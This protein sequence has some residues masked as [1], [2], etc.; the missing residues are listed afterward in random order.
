M[1]LTSGTKLGPYEIQSP[2]GAGG[3]GEVYRAR[4]TRLDR[5]VA[6]KVLPSRLSDQAEARERFD[7]EARAVSSLNHPHICHLYD[8]GSQD[9]VSYLVMELLEGESLA[10]RLRRG[11]L[12]LEQVLRCGAEIAE[13]LQ[14]AHRCGVAH[15]DLKPGNVMLTKAGAKL[16]DFGLAK[17]MTPRNPQTSE[18]TATLTSHNATPLTAQGTIVGTFQYMSPE[19]V[20]GKETD[21]RSDIFSLGAVLYEMATG[22][23]AF[24]G[25]T[26]VSVAAAILEK[27]PEPIT[28][29]QPM[30]PSGLQHV[31]QGCLAKDP[32]SRWQSA[33]DIVRELRWIAGSGSQTG[34]PALRPPSRRWR[35][36]AV[37]GAAV[38]VLLA[39]CLWALLSR[40]QRHVLRASLL[41]P[42]NATYDLIGDFSGPPALSPDGT[43]LV[44]AAHSAK[45]QNVLWVRNLEGVVQKLAGTEGGY[46]PFWSP[47][48]RFIGFFSAGKLSKIPAGGGPVI[49]LADAA[50]ARGGAWGKDNVI[51][52]APDYRGSLMRVN[53]TGANVPAQATKIDPTRHS[54]HRWPMFLPDGRHFMFLATNHA[55]VS[56]EQNG[57]YLAS[58]DDDRSK[59]VLANDSQAQYA[60]GYLLFHQQH[61]VMAQKFD[62][63]SGTLSGEQQ[64]VADDVQ[65]DSGTWHT[66]FTAT[67]DGLFVYEPGSSGIAADYGLI[68]TDRS[69]K[70][71]GTV[72]EHTAYKGMR[73]SPD[74]KRLVVAI[75]DPLIDIWVFDLERG[76]KTRLT[77][78]PVTHLEPAWSPDGQKVVFMVQNGSRIQS[79][80]TLHARLASGGGQDELLLGDDPGSPMT[81]MW[82]QISADGQY[83]VY[84]KQNGP[85]GTS[86][87]A[88]PLTGDRKPFVVVKPES[89]EGTVTYSRLSP[90]GRWLAY[91][92]RDSG[93]EETYVTSFPGGRGR[94]QVSTEGGT[95]PVWRGDGK[96]IFYIGF[97]GQL[98]AVET[99]PGKENFAAGRSQTL[100]G[101]RYVA[102][103][104][105]PYDVSPDG[106]RILVA[107][108]L[109][110][111]S[112]PLVLVSDWTAELE[113]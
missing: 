25:K 18:L 10:E 69:G 84:Q 85:D 89:A 26:M 68:W 64:I 105:A 36:R 93:R 20:E 106:R 5:S 56:S 72:G 74:G 99:I 111:E 95:F 37:W 30:T 28:T 52:Y 47:D 70:S 91:S 48:S 109:T 22:K 57:I 65:Y 51:V 41:P 29:I 83:L 77:F 59:L 113:R 14:A 102:P 110:S 23:R 79:G 78:D 17:G 33:A 24:E 92:L 19:Q 62:P 87:W 98:H 42:A 15:R 88:M 73:L 12:P 63:A 108:P 104:F 61:A 39:A 38:M 35:E 112:E 3:M 53:A 9:G 94:W 101:V 90:D 54:T 6:I 71:L 13:G 97:D 76:T 75:G 81:L 107:F 44:F 32:D 50:N 55:G 40:P 60:A 100:F 49:A 103:Y 31:V 21:A 86:V 8:V 58:L 16:M 80:S 82:P 11:P 66:T 1:A 43:R 4:D 46:C 34:A 96:E 45:E 2:L 7:R 27:E 67:D